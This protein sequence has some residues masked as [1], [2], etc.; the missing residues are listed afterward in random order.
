MLREAGMPVAPPSRC[1]DPECQEL[2]TEGRCEAHRRKAW[3]NRS[4]SWGSGSTRK[5]REARKRQLAEEPNCR[6]CGA[7][8]TQVDH[9]V[10]LSEGGSKWDPANW[11]SLCGDCHDVKSAEDRRRRTRIDGSRLTS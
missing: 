1:A 7:K 11:Q 6:R 9:V 5:W 2:T 8:A 4:K 3:A 10:P